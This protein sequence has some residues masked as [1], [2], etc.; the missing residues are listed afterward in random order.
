MPDSSLTVQICHPE[1]SSWNI[2]PDEPDRRGIEGSQ[3]YF[4]LRNRFKAFSREFPVAA[5]AI[6]ISSG[7]F[8][9]RSLAFALAQHDRFEKF[10]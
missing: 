7:C 6:E 1:R 10:D 4:D 2:F 3:E 8:D 9:S 5:C